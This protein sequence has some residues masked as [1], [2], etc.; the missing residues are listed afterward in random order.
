MPY[1]VDVYGMSRVTAAEHASLLLLGVA[2]G[3]LVVGCASD[4]LRSRRGVMRVCTLLYALSWL[5]WILH[6]QWPLRGHA[7]VVLR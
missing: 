2:F 7:G 6:A 5:P 3:A 1:L 4:R